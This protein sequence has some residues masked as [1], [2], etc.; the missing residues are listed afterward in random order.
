MKFEQ[1][2]QVLEVARTGTFSQ[3]ARNLFMSQPN[4]SLSVRQLEE[5]LGCRLF[6][7][8]S[9]GV[10]PTEDGK[11]LIEHMAMIHMKYK[12]MKDYSQ[13]KLPKRLTLRIATTSLN[14]SVPQLI[15]ISEKYMGSPIQFH[16]L[17]YNS[18]QDIIDQ[19]ASC[20]VDFG[21]IG[22]MSPYVKNTLSKLHNLQIEYHCFS[23]NPVYAV[24]GPRNHFYDAARAL[25]VTD[26][27]EETILTFGSA[28]EDP[29]GAIFDATQERLQVKG[30]IVVNNCYLFYEMLQN[31]GAIGLIST[32]RQSFSRQSDRKNLHLLEISDFPIQAETGWIK[33]RRMPLTDIASELIEE[34]APVM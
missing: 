10:I 5:E 29:C 12:T 9:E 17:N 26:L 16:L 19:V 25:S 33:L 27:R 1:L 14:R 11:I 4:L 7:R 3:A 21:I 20:Q 13:G 28:M 31:T 2:E 30:R 6:V 34:L 15:R 18:L 8:T 32:N 23:V 24:M 22:M